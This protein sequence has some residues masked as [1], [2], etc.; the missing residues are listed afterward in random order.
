MSLRL[1]TGS[2]PLGSA[3]MVSLW[4]SPSLLVA[5]VQR[6]STSIT[7]ANYSATSTISSVNTNY[8]VVSC[9]GNGNGG[10]ANRSLIPYI[11]LTNATTLTAT[12]PY[13]D[14]SN[15]STI[16]WEV[17]EFYPGVVRNI[18]SFSLSFTGGPTPTATLTT[19]NTSKSLL[20]YRGVDQPGGYG[21]DLASYT[22]YPVTNVDSSTQVSGSIG[23]WGDGRIFATLVELY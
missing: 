11:Q 21:G 2:G 8:S 22:A 12:R 14:G 17:I 6:G 7:G 23:A 16:Y 15:S 19:F 3:G 13:Q 5:S 18:Q 4:N 20:F 1:G 10:V 9:R